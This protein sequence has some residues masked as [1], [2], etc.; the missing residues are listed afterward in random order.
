M[1]MDVMAPTPESRV[2]DVGV[3]GMLTRENNY[4]EA[5][6][7]WPARIT[8][9]A[10]RDEPGFRA[11]FPEVEL[12]VADGRALP[13]PDD[14]F[15]IAFS[16]AVVEHVG[17]REQQERFVAEV[18]RV[19]RRAWIST[20][21]ARFPVDPHTM[22]PFAG[23]LPRRWRDPIYARTGNAQW[24]GEEA[25]HPLDERA[26]RALFPPDVRV[27]IVRQRLLGL[28]SVLVAVTA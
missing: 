25:L 14:A 10:L 15:D 8:A 2:L 28:T 7:P 16:N 27:R 20:P 5:L 19:S 17:S 1:F 12:V 4:L 11:H 13:F 6:Y 3:A 9:V 22:L 21:N 26:F 23:W 24:V 18:C